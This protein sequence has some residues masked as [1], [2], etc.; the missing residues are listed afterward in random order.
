MFLEHLANWGGAW[1]AVDFEHVA[2]SILFF[3]GGLCGMLCES[4][5]VR[6]WINSTAL[7]KP[8]SHPA[9]HDN[10]SWS[11]PKSQTVSLNPMPA[12]V[13]LLLGSMMGSHHQDSML[14]SMIHTQWGNLLTG[15]A[16]ARLVTC[17]LMYLNPPTSYLPSR[18][19]SE[20]LASFC[21]MGGGLV[22]MMSVSYTYISKMLENTWLT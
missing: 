12:L 9:A 4:K 13:I 2:I 19:P 7:Q 15:F 1:T 6:D 20:I 8:P 16:I 18:P 5:H 14:S 10:S 3:G 21:L 22:F 17:A 11:I